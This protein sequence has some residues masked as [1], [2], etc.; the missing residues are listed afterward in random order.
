MKK[1]LFEFLN[2][3]WCLPQTLLGLIL[4]LIFRGK[5]RIYIS[6]DGDYV[7]YSYNCNSGS[8]SL[9][10]Y[11]LLCPVHKMCLEVIKHELGHQKQSYILGPLYLIIVGL[12]S[13]I[14]AKFYGKFKYKLKGT[15]YSFYTEKWANRLGGVDNYD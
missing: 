13:L 3:T 5:K 1:I 6:G 15:Y 4:K 9:G 14:W 2:W 8:I 10:K 12:P 11:V 7:Y